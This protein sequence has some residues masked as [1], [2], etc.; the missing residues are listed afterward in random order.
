M[1]CEMKTTIKICY[2][3]RWCTEKFEIEGHA[4]LDN[5]IMTDRLHSVHCCNETLHKQS[6]DI[7]LRY[8]VGDLIGYKIV[9]GKP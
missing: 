6:K 5:F 8:G 9:K 4:G 7:P 1:W 3:C 2:K